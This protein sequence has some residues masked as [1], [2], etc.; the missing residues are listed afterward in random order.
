MPEDIAKL[1]STSAPKLKYRKEWGPQAVRAS[2]VPPRVPPTHCCCCACACL[3]LSPC[4]FGCVYARQAA[5][6]VPPTAF[7]ARAVRVCARVNVA[8]IRR[9]GSAL[10]LLVRGACSCCGSNLGCVCT[11]GAWTGP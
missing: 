4:R 2:A 5:W 10:Q 6:G 3:P 8:S 11:S 1:A 7:T 9:D